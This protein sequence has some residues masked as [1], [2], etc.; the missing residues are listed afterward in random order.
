MKSL[1]YTREQEARLLARAAPQVARQV[2]VDVVDETVQAAI[3]AVGEPRGHFTG[4]VLDCRQPD[5][6]WRS[7]DI[8]A[9]AAPSAVPGTGNLRFAAH[10]I[11]V[12]NNG[13]VD[14][15]IT[16]DVHDDAGNLILSKNQDT[17]VGGILYAPDADYTFDMPTHDYT[18][19]AR[20]MH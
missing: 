17:P 2:G 13:T 16:V 5:G 14:G 20:A 11:A 8:L 7:F 3:A 9:G 18:L 10:S 15:W 1:A 12:T 6:T 19:T 4:L